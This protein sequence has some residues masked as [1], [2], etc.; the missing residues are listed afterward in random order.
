MESSFSTIWVKVGSDRLGE[1]LRA[2]LFYKGSM[3]LTRTIS[4]FIW[5]GLTIRDSRGGLKKEILFFFLC[6]WG[7]PGGL[8]RFLSYREGGKLNRL[9]SS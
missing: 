6:M 7:Y 8:D 5:A 2:R 1:K 4:F 3:L 9:F